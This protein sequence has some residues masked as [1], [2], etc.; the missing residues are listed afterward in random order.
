[1]YML[2]R[3]HGGQTRRRTQHRALRVTCKDLHK[4]IL[5]KC[6][7]GVLCDGA[8]GMGGGRPTVVVRLSC[9]SEP[10]CVV[11]VRFDGFACPG[12]TTRLLDEYVRLSLSTPPKHLT[13]AHRPNTKQS[14]SNQALK[15]PYEA[16]IDCFLRH[17]YTSYTRGLFIII[18]LKCFVII[19]KPVNIN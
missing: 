10:V 18:I 17:V 19:C 9:L 8:S 6:L 5:L 3:H 13:V 4:K 1:M 2:R 16:K 12:A 15:R 14:I 7:A 11:S